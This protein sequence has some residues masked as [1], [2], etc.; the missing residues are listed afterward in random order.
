MTHQRKEIR[1]AIVSILSGAS[2]VAAGRVYS[3]RTLTL[4]YDQDEIPA[5]NVT[6]LPETS[7]VDEFSGASGLMRE[8]TVTIEAVVASRDNETIDDAMDE[9]A[10]KIEIAMESDQSLSGNVIDSYLTGTD[11]DIESDGNVTLAYVRLEYL[12][13]YQA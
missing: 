10:E 2:I 12:V 3:N 7:S 1:D 11:G 9:I 13:R 8:L 5:I 4:D 6:T